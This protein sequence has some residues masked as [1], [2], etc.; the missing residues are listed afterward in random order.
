MAYKVFISHS[1][2]DQGLVIAVSN[3]LARYG[4]NVAVAE[5]YSDKEQP[6]SRRVTS[7]I[8][9]ADIVVVLLTP[10]GKRTNWVKKEVSV[11]LAARRLLIPLVERGISARELV[12]LQ[13]LK[14]IL[15]DPASPE[16]SLIDASDHIHTLRLTRPERER[17]LSMTGSALAFAM[18]HSGRAE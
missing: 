9:G 4:A 5:W 11:A 6:I 16:R 13:G 18:L 8:R 7:Q 10:G 3:L 15:Y 2:R 14:W 1:T 12:P 17:A